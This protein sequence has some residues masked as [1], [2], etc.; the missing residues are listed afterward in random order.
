MLAD[1]RRCG[2]CE[3]PHNILQLRRGKE[4]RHVIVDSSA[5]RR[6]SRSVS[7]SG[8]PFYKQQDMGVSQ[9]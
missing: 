7:E 8:S 1:W 5:Y 4:A 6:T 9:N 2:A 3:M